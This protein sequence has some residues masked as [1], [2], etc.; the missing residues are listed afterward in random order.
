MVPPDSTRSLPIDTMAVDVILQRFAA[1]LQE[2]QLALMKQ[3]LDQLE[4]FMDP[5]EGVVLPDRSEPRSLVELGLLPAFYVVPEMLVD[6]RM[7]MVMRST[8]GTRVGVTSSG[9]PS[10]LD[11]MRPDGAGPSLAATPIDAGE[12]G[13][14]SYPPEDGGGVT[15]RLVTTPVPPALMMLLEQQRRARGEGTGG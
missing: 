5:K 1:A 3:S 9:L 15:A 10:L 2:T 7:S 11:Q 12:A 13:R 6:I 4:R 14:Y 8:S